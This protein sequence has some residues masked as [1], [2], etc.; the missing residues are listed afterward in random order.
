MC[1]LQ[2]P[3]LRIPL[4]PLRWRLGLLLLLPRDERL[5]LEIPLL[6]DKIL[7][8]KLTALVRPDADDEDDNEGDDDDEDDS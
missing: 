6:E 7:V 1:P 5:P 8:A 2:L 3:L 4:L